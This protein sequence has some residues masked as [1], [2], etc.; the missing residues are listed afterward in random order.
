MI[1]EL[2][3]LRAWL[4]SIRGDWSRLSRKTGV[5]TRTIYRIVNDDSYNLTLQT[6]VT[7][8]KERPR[9]QPSEAATEQTAA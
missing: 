2:A 5:S 1:K 4:A 8:D 3:E 7:L 9:D 6:F